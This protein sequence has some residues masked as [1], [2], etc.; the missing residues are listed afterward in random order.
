MKKYKV[1]A[2]QVFQVEETVEANSIEEAK[3][4]VYQEYTEYD[5]DVQDE[6][7]TFLVLDEDD[8]FFD[9]IREEDD[10]SLKWDQD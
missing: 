1:I 5:M 8:P 9:K 2:V 6:C 4:K 3:E 7:P 10:A